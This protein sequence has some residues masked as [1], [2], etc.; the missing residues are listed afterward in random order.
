MTTTVEEP[1]VDRVAE[2][3]FCSRV[4]AFIETHCARIGEDLALEGEAALFAQNRLRG[5]AQTG[6]IGVG[7]AVNLRT[8]SGPGSRPATAADLFLDPR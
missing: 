8:D 1:S 5:H 4:E 2:T 3:E 6:G 7:H